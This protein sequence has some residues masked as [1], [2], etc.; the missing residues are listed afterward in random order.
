MVTKC[1]TFGF[2]H[3]HPHG[4]VR[5]ARATEPECREEMFRRYGNQWAF[6]YTEAE[7]NDQMTRFPLLYEVRE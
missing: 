2:G 1:F 3:S 6:E 7:I 5:I 4:F